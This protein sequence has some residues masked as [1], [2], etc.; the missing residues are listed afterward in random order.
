MPAPRGQTESGPNGSRTG[1]PALQQY[2]G[3]A[4]GRRAQARVYA[5]TQQ[6]VVAAPDVVTAIVV[7]MNMNACEIGRAHV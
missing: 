2:P 5:A 4:S 6:E 1:A 3:E 7:L